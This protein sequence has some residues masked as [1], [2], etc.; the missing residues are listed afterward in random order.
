[1]C[2][3]NENKYDFGSINQPHKNEE[4]RHQN[5]PI[6]GLKSCEKEN[7]FADEIDL[8]YTIYMAHGMMYFQNINIV[9]MKLILLNNLD[10]LQVV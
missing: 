7:L 6:E 2:N 1:M 8:K 3:L 5:N 10:K 9:N 4:I